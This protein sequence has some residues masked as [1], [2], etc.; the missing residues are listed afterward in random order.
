M[1]RTSVEDGDDRSEQRRPGLVMKSDYD[2]GLLQLIW[3]PVYVPAVAVS[4]VRNR[5]IRSQF[6]RLYLIELVG[7]VCIATL[8]DQRLRDVAG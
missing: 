6:I 8:S 4:R 3:L 5:S 2:T 1:L 7:G